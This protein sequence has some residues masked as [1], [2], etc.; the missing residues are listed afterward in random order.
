MRKMPILKRADGLFRIKQDHPFN[1]SF[2][3]LAEFIAFKCIHQAV[4]CRTV[5]AFGCISASL[6][7]TRFRKKLFFRGRWYGLILF[8]HIHPFY[9]EIN[10]RSKVRLPGF[11]IQRIKIGISNFIRV[12]FISQ[13]CKAV[14]EFMYEY[15]CCMKIAVYANLVVVEYCPSPVLGGVDQDIN[16][17]IR[18]I[19]CK[20]ANA[21]IIIGHTVSFAIESVKGSIHQGPFPGCICRDIGA[22]IC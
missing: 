22:G 1:S 12:V 21:F 18:S 20:V 13:T 11:N 7:D 15:F 16:L 6:E 14:P 4:V 10:K 9:L 17:I 2:T 19:G 3:N 8:E 5:Y